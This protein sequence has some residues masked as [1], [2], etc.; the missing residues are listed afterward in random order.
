MKTTAVGVTVLA[1]VLIGM[2]VAGADEAAGDAAPRIEVGMRVMVTLATGVSFTGEVA[3]V[4]EDRLTLDFAKEPLGFSGEITF[5]YEQIRSVEI[6][7]DL[8]SEEIEDI[9]ARRDEEVERERA[10]QAAAPDQD[11]IEAEEWTVEE[12]TDEETGLRLQMGIQKMSGAERK[13]DAFESI[14]VGAARVRVAASDHFFFVSD[15]PVGGRITG[16]FETAYSRVEK[17]C[18]LRSSRHELA[19]YVYGKQ[20]DFDD[21]SDERQAG[22]TWLSG[23]WYVDK[24]RLTLRAF[25]DPFGNYIAVSRDNAFKEDVVARMVAAAVAVEVLGVDFAE[26]TLWFHEGFKEYFARTASGESYPRM[27]Q[28][29]PVY[30]PQPVEVR[31]ADLRRLFRR[32]FIAPLRDFYRLAAGSVVDFMIN[33]PYRVDFPACLSYLGDSPASAMTN[34]VVIIESAFRMDFA[35]FE[36][37]WREYC[38]IERELR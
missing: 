26:D 9:L 21:F 20:S 25:Y 15:F 36:K 22:W 7:P 16:R 10:R 3:N 2:S 8:S 19:V 1:W 30:F 33:G 32:R 18:S 28:P 35:Q 38:L 24:H 12:S 11:E 27:R 6:L 14:G 5:N 4:Q 34:H 17:A 29:A 23:D 31:H 37:R 13:R